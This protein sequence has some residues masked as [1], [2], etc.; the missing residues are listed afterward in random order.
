[1]EREQRPHLRINMVKMKL[2]SPS[3]I[4]DLCLN[5]VHTTVLVDRLVAGELLTPVAEGDN[6]SDLAEEVVPVEETNQDDGVKDFEDEDL[7]GRIMINRNVFV[8]QVFK[9]RMS[10]NYS[11]KSSLTDW[12]NSALKLWK[13]RMCIYPSPLHERP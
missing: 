12:P 1:M 4:L 5:H 10:G 9:S 8:M 2:P 3:S 6:Y 11:R 13:E 7:V